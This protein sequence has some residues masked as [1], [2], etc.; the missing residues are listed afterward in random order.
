MYRFVSHMF[1]KKIKYQH[2]RLFPKDILTKNV[3]YQC[4]EL[5]PKNMFWPNMTAYSFVKKG[6]TLSS[7]KLS[8]TT[9]ALK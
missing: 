2:K 4:Q 7:G 1:A 8:L 6:I 5:L 9:K 3:K